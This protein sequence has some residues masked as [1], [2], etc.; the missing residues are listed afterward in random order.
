MIATEHR[1]SELISLYKKLANVFDS[2]AKTKS[3]KISNYVTRQN[4]LKSLSSLNLSKILVVGAAGDWSS[5][6]AKNGFEVNLIDPNIEVLKQAEEKF[7]E[8]GLSVNIIEGEFENTKF[9]N[10]E[11]DLVF[12]D[13]GIISLFPDP[14]NMMNEFRRVTKSGGYIWIDYLNLL[15]WSILQPDVESRLLLANK[16]EEII[17]MGKDE[18]PMRFFSPKKIRHMLYDAGF[19]EL[20]EFG[21]GIL[22]NPM[23]DDQ[24][25]KGSEEDLKKTELDLSRNYNLNGSAFHIQVLAQKIIY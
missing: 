25:V 19:L 3:A 2:D 6:L 12:A 20:N 4:L 8:Q 7:F 5:F 17:Y 22:T 24:Q 1:V 23:M 13:E 10:H 15:G 16:D 21:N 11:F 14:V 9:A 18:F